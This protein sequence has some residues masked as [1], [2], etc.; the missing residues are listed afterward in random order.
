[1]KPK[2]LFMSEPEADFIQRLE[3][4]YEVLIPPPPGVDRD[5][6][7]QTTAAGA[8]ALIT[9]APLAPRGAQLEALT[10][11][12]T[13]VFLGAGYQGL[14][15][16]AFQKLGVTGCFVPGANSAAVAEYTVA[17]VLAAVR[18]IVPADAF[19]RD[20]RWGP[21]FGPPLTQNLYGKT[22]GFLG[23]GNSGLQAARR[24]EAFECGIVYHKPTP[25]Y[26]V[27]YRYFETLPEMA[28]MAD[29]LVI[30]CPGG[31]ATHKVV[32]ADVLDA[33]G[34]DGYVVN[35][36]RG[37]VI[38]TDA[39]LGAL[40]QGRIAGAALDVFE[41]EPGAPDEFKALDNVVLSPHR[42]GVTYDAVRAQ[43]E[44][45]M[46]NLTAHFSG[47]LLLTPIPELPGG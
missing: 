1:M 36:S 41:N 43:W 6:F 18:R 9:I 11:L 10:G 21:E 45:A 39:L 7:F 20:G 12:E 34:V 47:E 16:P 28:A 23:L 35:I 3:A 13:V 24:L 30:A 46:K 2:V 4:E 25:R 32:N 31:Q 8:Q 37:S 38:D 27:T 5:M 14:E 29:I 17:L 40:Q 44:V 15:L 33:L 26:D 42:A 19:V 22:V